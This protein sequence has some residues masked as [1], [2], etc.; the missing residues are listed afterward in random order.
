[1]KHLKSMT[2]LKG[3]GQPSTIYTD[4]STDF[5][6]F[7]ILCKMLKVLSLLLYIKKPF[8]MHNSM[9]FIS[10]LCMTP[11]TDGPPNH[12]LLMTDSRE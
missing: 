7:S 11:Y 8:P 10:T 2:M 6:P 3:N 4:Y 5:I 12:L 1:M 9:F